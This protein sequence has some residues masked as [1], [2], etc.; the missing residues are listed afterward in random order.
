MSMVS[1]LVLWWVPCAAYI[2][3]KAKDFAVINF[4]FRQLTYALSTIL[5]FVAFNT[6]TLCDGVGCSCGS[7]VSR[8]RQTHAGTSLVR[9][10]WAL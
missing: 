6:L 8:T 10:L 7:G 5:P 1:D 3:K 2:R 4:P 9:V